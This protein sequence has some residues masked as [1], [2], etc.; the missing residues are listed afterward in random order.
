ME[1]L[2]MVI[3]KYGNKMKTLIETALR[4]I[5]LKLL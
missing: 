4:M 3:L 2:I 1:I 5:L